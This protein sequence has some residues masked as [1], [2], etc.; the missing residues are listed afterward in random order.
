MIVL[1]V[2]DHKPHAIIITN[3]I[4]LIV[5]DHK[6]DVTQVH[7]PRP[8]QRGQLNLQPGQKCS[9]Q[10]KKNLKIK[11]TCSCQAARK[12]SFCFKHNNLKL[13]MLIGADRCFFMLIDAY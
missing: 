6:T 7:G 11:H 10:P 12:C 8:K 1:I 5:I 3:M 4:V 9:C 13:I 2:I